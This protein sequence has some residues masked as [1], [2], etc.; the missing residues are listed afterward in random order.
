MQ[1][2]D[3]SKVLSGETDVSAMSNAKFNEL[4]KDLGRV[5]LARVLNCIDPSGKSDREWTAL[6]CIF[7]RIAAILVETSNNAKMRDALS[8]LVSYLDKEVRRTE[9][10]K[11]CKFNGKS[12]RGEP[13]YWHVDCG[14]DEHDDRASG[15][16]TYL[17]KEFNLHAALA[18]PPRNCDVGTAEQQTERF[19][20]YCNARQD[21]VVC[22][23]DCPLRHASTLC[24]FA[25]SQMP[26][27]EGDDDGSD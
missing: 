3:I 12:F 14:I 2:E 15:K 22:S 25:W 24:E 17:L 4:V 20:N 27:E 11:Q 23:D 1:E 26:Y 19:E 5:Y 8:N 21:D 13:C 18:A 6:S 7:N 9:K 10:C 16:A